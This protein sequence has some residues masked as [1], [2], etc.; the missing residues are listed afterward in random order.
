MQP[1]FSP[2]TTDNL[3]AVFHLIRERIRW[4]DEMGLEQWNK[5]DY[6]DVYPPSY[7]E[8]AAA[9]GRLFVLRES[10]AEVIIAAGV[11]SCSDARWP[12]DGKGLYLHNFV[13]ALHA[14]G[15]GVVFLSEAE[16]YAR[17]KGKSF[18]RLDCAASNRRLNDYYES[19]GYH[20]VGSVNDRDYL[21]I[22]REK[23]LL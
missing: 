9:E 18:L 17:R 23:A 13:A 1:C 21:G 7:Y 2:G 3:E 4:M 19:H 10:G 15:A 16:A 22:L 6:W 8:K 11:L 12:A 20:A 5:E 14:K